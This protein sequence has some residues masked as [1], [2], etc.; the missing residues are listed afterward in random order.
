MKKLSAGRRHISFRCLSPYGH[1]AV[2]MFVFFTT[3]TTNQYI[4]LYLYEVG[5][6]KTEIGLLTGTAGLIALVC[7]PVLGGIADLAPS[8]K[9]MMA[10]VLIIA[11][12]AFPG[13]YF[14]RGAI[15]IFL[16]YTVFHIF[17]SFSVTLN[18]AM[19]VEYCQL[20]ERPYGPMRMLGALSYSLMMFV[21]S[22]AVG[23]T[24]DV[25][26]LLFPGAC[27]LSLGCLIPCPDVKGSNGR[28]SGLEHL[29]PVLLL[30]DR[31]VVILICFQTLIGIATGIS[32]GFFSIYFTD[33]MGG[34]AKEFALCVAIA[35][36][37]EVP[38]LFLTDRWL[39]WLGPRKMLLMLCAFTA[40]RH[41]LCFAANSV[42][43]LFLARCMNFFNVVESVAYSLILIRIVRPQ[44]KTSAQTLS[45]TV[46]TV[47]NLMVSSY[48]GGFLADQVGIRPLFAVS[49]ILIVVFSLLFTFWVFPRTLQKDML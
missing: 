32:N 8:K 20:H 31:T 13:M 6:T 34:T 12:V 38:F 16:L 30:K 37:C 45:S 44:L 5:F 48:L 40:L 21:I 42:A 1:L 43:V 15:W 35:A 25:I 14:G 2:F 26:F 18:N 10:I 23:Q 4:Q 3:Q 39:K 36:M 27:L 49:G 41:F 9:R 22:A 19:A 29:S 17:F 33:D 47:A 11:T 7:Q 24:V 28:N 46:Q